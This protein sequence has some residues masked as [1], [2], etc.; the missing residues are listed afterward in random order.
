MT[1]GEYVPVKLARMRRE[2][3]DLAAERSVHQNRVKELD[4]QITRKS[5]D[6]AEEEAYFASKAEPPASVAEAYY[7]G[8]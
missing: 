7:D 2:I 6:L 5:K 3:N 1:E 8:C 4:E